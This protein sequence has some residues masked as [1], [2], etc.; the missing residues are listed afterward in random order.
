[1][2]QQDTDPED[3]SSVLGT[4]RLEEENYESCPL[5]SKHAAWHLYTT[6]HHTHEIKINMIHFL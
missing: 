6:S 3:L 4:H 5:A 2:A 1:M